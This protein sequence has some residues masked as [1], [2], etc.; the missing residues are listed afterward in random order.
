MKC[1]KTSAYLLPNLLSS[2]P[3]FMI[4]FWIEGPFDA[5][6]VILALSHSEEKRSKA[7]KNDGLHVDAVLVS[8][9]ERAFD[10]QI[11]GLTY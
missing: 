4:D 7:D 9:E 5:G 6:D 2:S 10:L 1:F 8:C 3:V 11:T